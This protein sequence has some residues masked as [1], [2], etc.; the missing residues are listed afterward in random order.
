MLGNGGG[1]IDDPFVI[2]QIVAGVGLVDNGYAKLTAKTLVDPRLV[3]GENTAVIIVL[4][5]SNG[6]NHVNALYTPTNVKV[7]NFGVL[8]G[9]LY[10]A[11][12]PLLG[13]SGSNGNW[14]GRLG[15]K[16]ID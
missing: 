12:D 16:L 15:D 3:S 14:L 5:Q 1:S 13:C 6:A 10:R 8:N 2:S 11:A 7:E 9:G 4:G